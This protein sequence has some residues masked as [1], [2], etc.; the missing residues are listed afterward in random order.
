MKRVLV[1]FGTRPE[2]IKL[3]P[4]LEQLKS[5]DAFRI[6]T[7]CTG[8][9]RELIDPFLS[10]FQ[11]PADLDLNLMRPGQSLSHLHTALVAGVGDALAQ[12][13][14]D[15][16]VVQGDTSSAMASA[17]AAYHMRVPVAHVEAGLRTFDNQQPFPEEMNRRLIDSVADVCFAPT[18]TNRQNLLREGV[19]AESI[20]VTGN[21]A[22][23]ALKALIET[24][25]LAPHV[26]GAPLEMP[27][28]LVTAH[29]RENHG[30]PLQNICC[31]LL[32]ILALFDG[33]HAYYPLHPNPAVVDT[34]K[35]ILGNHPRVHLLPP[36]GYSEFVTLLR[37]CRFALSDSGGVQEEACYLGKPVLVLRE[38]TERPE[39]IQVGNGV[40][41][42]AETGRI[43]AEARQLL[44]D[45][46]MYRARA[47]SHTVFGDGNSSV[48][49]AAVLAERLRE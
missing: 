36:L 12:T 14:A 43:V 29:R 21:T 1:V 37:F 28:L 31:A 11:I 17:L 41:V 19:P 26:Q 2:A 45:E 10:F 39:L 38:K 44:E 46:D 18:E 15:W 49:I 4:L 13:R 32:E 48:R 25:P 5:D 9:H 24:R 7:C 20:F 42:G 35:P 30:R 3:A 34:V 33:I 8:Q 22:I 40:L 16:V 6:F 47:V 27:Y 23:D